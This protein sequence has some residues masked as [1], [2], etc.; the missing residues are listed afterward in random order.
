MRPISVFLGG[1][2][3]ALSVALS[4]VGPAS[5]QGGLTKKEK[6]EET[7]KDAATAQESYRTSHPTYTESRAALEAEGLVVRRGVRFLV[8]HADRDSY[9]MDAKHRRARRWQ[10]YYSEDG[11]PTPGRC[12]PQEN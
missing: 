6:A 9:C 10:H 3:L 5:A 8:V 12:T 7:L 1:G 2:V 11:A 4:S